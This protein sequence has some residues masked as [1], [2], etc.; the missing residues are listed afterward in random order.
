MKPRRYGSV[1]GGSGSFGFSGLFKGGMGTQAKS[2]LSSASAA[3][4]PIVKRSGSRR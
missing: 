3:P 1:F 2:V 4:L